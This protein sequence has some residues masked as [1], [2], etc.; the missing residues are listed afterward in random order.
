MGIYK[1]LLDRGIYFMNYGKLQLS[2][3]LLLAMTT[4]L[5]LTCFF[6]VKHIILT[7]TSIIAMLLCILGLI[8]TLKAENKK[9]QKTSIHQKKDLS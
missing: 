8:Y 7:I 3:T 1:F 5:S 2:F 6:L 4:I 9:S